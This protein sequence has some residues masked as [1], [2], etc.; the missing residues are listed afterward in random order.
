[1][2]GV[3]PAPSLDRDKVE[4]DLR[5]MILTLELPPGAIVT[6]AA[7]AD[8]LRCGRMPLR[9]AVLRLA[10]DGL[11]ISVPRRGVAIPG[12]DLLDFKEL[13][14]ATIPTESFCMRLAAS[15][16]GAGDLEKLED[17]ARRAEEA[18][19]ASDFAAVVDLDM[20]FHQVMVRATGNRYLIKTMLGLHQVAMRFA[21]I[22]WSLEGSALKSWAEHRQILSAF[23]RHD[24]DE[25]ERVGREHTIASRDRIIDSLRFGA[26]SR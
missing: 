2:P 12:L 8:R 23:Q 11:V 9:E 7:L 6:H 25:A 26:S 24:P 4:Q 14:E 18:S 21:G 16:I 13:G 17:Y 10:N 3:N 20:D 22:A 15:R 5:R 1:M 19:R